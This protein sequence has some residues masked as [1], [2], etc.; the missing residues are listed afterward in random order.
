LKARR[1]VGE[2]TPS[3]MNRV[4]RVLIRWDKKVCHDLAFLQMACAYI[5][6][7]QA[8]LLG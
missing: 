7:R 6:Y 1:W 4:R 8:D 3:G 2:R 5:A